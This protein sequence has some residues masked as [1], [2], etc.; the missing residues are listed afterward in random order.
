M[1]RPAAKSAKDML[2]VLTRNFE[3]SLISGIVYHTNLGQNLVLYF[4][5]G[6]STATKI[7]VVIVA[8]TNCESHKAF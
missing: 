8:V 5:I 3:V 2:T 7:F 4:K 1:R 6:R